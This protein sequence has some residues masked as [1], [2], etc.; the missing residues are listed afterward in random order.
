MQSCY[1]ELHKRNWGIENTVSQR[2]LHQVNKLNWKM[3]RLYYKMRSRCR[4]RIRKCQGNLL[5]WDI[6]QMMNIGC[7]APFGQTVVSGI[8]FLPPPGNMLI[9]NTGET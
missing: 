6:D 5:K 1:D 3:S 8:P 2:L 4:K 7:H 9:K